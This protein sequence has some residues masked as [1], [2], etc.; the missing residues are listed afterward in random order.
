MEDLIFIH[1]SWVI[2]VYN[3]KQYDSLQTYNSI[4]KVNLCLFKLN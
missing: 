2:Y 4:Y 1:G 3:E